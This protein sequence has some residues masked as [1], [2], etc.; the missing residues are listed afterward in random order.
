V[1]R[2]RQ[3]GHY[4]DDRRRPGRFS[5]HFHLRPGRLPPGA[6]LAVSKSRRRRGALQG[7]T[8]C[9][10]MSKAPAKAADYDGS[11]PWFKIKEWGPSFT[12]GQSSWPLS[13]E[14]HHEQGTGHSGH[15]TDQLLATYTYNIPKC[16][17]NGEYLL[18]IESLG[19]HNPGSTPQ[20]YV[21]CA[22]V[23]VV[24]GGST[25]PSPTALIPGHV[26]ATDPGYTANVS[27]GLRM[28]LL[29]LYPWL[30]RCVDL[31]QLQVVHR[32]RT[33]RGKFQVETLGCPTA[34]H[35]S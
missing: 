4:H 30:T 35:E 24:G 6:R 23:N 32:S 18:R 25:T 1:Q 3:L 11:G 7:L 31:Q 16:I 8:S 26:K 33:G 27:R 21:S 20:F 9:S 10:Y 29:S 34:A 12:G 19:I 15:A 17:A 22:Q 5:F 13:S 14:S 28:L 2:R